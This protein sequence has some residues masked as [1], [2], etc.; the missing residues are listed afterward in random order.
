M[1]I[2]IHCIQDPVFENL[3]GLLLPL[4]LTETG[5]YYA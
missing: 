1:I 4:Y 3:P 5:V 2:W